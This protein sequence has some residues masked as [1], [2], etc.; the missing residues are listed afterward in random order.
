MCS[1]QSLI[2]AIA[3]CMLC[4]CNRFNP[5]SSLSF[6]PDYRHID[7]D[8]ESLVPQL[9]SDNEYYLY[10][11]NIDDSV[12]VAYLSEGE[13]F[14]LAQNLNSGDTLSYL[15]RKGRGPLEF[16]LVSPRFSYRDGHAYLVDNMKSRLLD[17]DVRASIAKG[18]TVILKT[19]DLENDKD[20]I[21]HF[22]MSVRTEDGYLVSYHNNTSFGKEALDDEPAFQVNDAEN[23]AVLKSV[24]LFDNLTSK[25][26]DN[27]AMPV[28]GLVSIQGCE[29]PGSA[30]ICFAM[31]SLPV[32]GFFDY[33]NGTI[34][35]IYLENL[36]KFKRNKSI[37]YF[38]SITSDG[39]NI[40]ALLEG[41]DSPLDS[42]THVTSLIVM[43]IIGNINGYYTPIQVNS[44]TRV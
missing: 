17:V 37:S 33:K 23:G 3:C 16:L 25:R 22:N 31:H 14:L 32:I 18:E 39:E 38:S 34:R 11:F 40:Y 24:P 20:R 19:V 42:D 15:C 28:G 35:G 8:V 26:L 27:M 5:K 13:H 44:A 7:V 9:Y 10:D 2:V 43:D 36:P 1:R 41:S 12:L 4:S 30:Q 21:Q 6:L 29:I